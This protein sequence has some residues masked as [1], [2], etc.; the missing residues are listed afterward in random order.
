MWKALL[1]KGDY[2]QAS[3][4]LW[5]AA[6]QVVK[7]VAAKR[8]RALGMHRSLSQLVEE[9]HQQ[10]PSWGL[11]DAFAHANNLHVNFYEDHLTPGVICRGAEQVERFVARLRTLL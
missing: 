9:L 3:E 11:I 7:A 2:V 10:H 1:A 4:K 6:A 8:G 5:G